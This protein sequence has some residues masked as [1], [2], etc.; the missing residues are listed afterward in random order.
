MHVNAADFDDPN[1]KTFDYARALGCRYVTISRGG[2]FSEIL[3]D[4]VTQCAAIGKAAA[5]RGLQ[6]TYHNHAAEFEKID[7]KAALDLIFE[8]TDAR[9]VQM[10]LDVYWTAKGGESPVEYIKRYANRLPQLH[11]KDMDR[12]DGSFTELGN[13]CIDLA[14]CVEA[15]RGTICEWLIYEQ[16]VCKRPQFESAKSSIEYLNK[17]MGK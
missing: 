4:V 17:L 14:A 3:D 7:G 15:A 10:E 5:G 6:F 9:Q 8:R 12:E 1:N 11:L 13:G 16:D 2:V